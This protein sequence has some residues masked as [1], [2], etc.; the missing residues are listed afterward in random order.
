MLNVASRETNTGKALQCSGDQYD[1]LVQASIVLGFMH[2][3]HRYR[4]RER[5][6]AWRGMV[7]QLIG[8]EDPD[9]NGPS[10]SRSKHHTGT[11]YSARPTVIRFVDISSISNAT[12]DEITELISETRRL[13]VS[14]TVE[15]MIEAQTLSNVLSAVQVSSYGLQMPCY[16]KQLWKKRNL[17]KCVLQLKGKRSKKRRHNLSRLQL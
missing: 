6:I 16:S 1:R 13:L 12:R 15:I 10:N 5:R 8:L 17:A 2:Q 3:G 9:Q 7:D 11:N 14:Q 4:D